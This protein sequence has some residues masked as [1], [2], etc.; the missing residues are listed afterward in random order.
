MQF[1]VRSHVTFCFNAGCYYTYYERI[2]PQMQQYVSFTL[3][4]CFFC[5]SFVICRDEL[6][7]LLL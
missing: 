3:H 5:F 6:K 7:V 4:V 1:V 2:I